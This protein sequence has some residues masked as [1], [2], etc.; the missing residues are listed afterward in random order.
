VFSSLQSQVTKCA[1]SV[2]EPHAPQRHHSGQVAYAFL[3][4]NAAGEVSIGE[5]GRYAV[6]STP[7]FECSG[8]QR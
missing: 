7:S 2:G 3:S 8:G 6:A 4:Q 5:S 1:I